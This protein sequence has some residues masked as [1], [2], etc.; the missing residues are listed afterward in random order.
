M[1][2]GHSLLAYKSCLKGLHKLEL[3][4]KVLE[5]DLDANWELLA[6]PIQTVMRRHKVENAYEQLKELTRGKK[7]NK[8]TVHKFI[9]GLA[10]PSADKKRL[11]SL[12]PSTY[13]GLATELVDSYKP[14]FLSS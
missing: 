12:T 4:K 9:D 14:D 8:K 13:I 6:E 7:V 11:K 1:G 3:N 5:G 2:L 10:I